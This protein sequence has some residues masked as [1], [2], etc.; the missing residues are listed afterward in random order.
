MTI[1]DALVAMSEGNPG[2]IT[3]LMDVLHCA[4]RVDPQNIMQ[5]FGHVL[6]FD[7]LGI[8]GSN[9]YVLWN[10]FCG[11]S[12]TH[13]IALSRAYQ[14]GHLCGVTESKLHQAVDYGQERR[15][16]KPEFDFPAIFAAIKT[17][18]PSFNPGT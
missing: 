14:L 18:L 1:M 11:R 13:L 16:E 3:A 12:G 17:E 10:D 15:G 4:P 6:T 7:T 9:L 8:R 5:G 2:A